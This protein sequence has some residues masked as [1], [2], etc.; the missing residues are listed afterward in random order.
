MLN[1]P[2]NKQQASVEDWTRLNVSQKQLAPKTLP[3]MLQL[4]KNKFTE[5]LFKEVRDELIKVNST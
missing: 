4:S 3:A 2:F 5:E 1:V